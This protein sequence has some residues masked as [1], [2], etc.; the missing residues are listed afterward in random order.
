MCCADG[1]HL[2]RPDWRQHGWSFACY[3]YQ[4]LPPDSY[5]GN[6]PARW[7]SARRQRWRH[8]RWRRP[9]SRRKSVPVWQSR[10]IE[11]RRCAGRVRRRPSRRQ[12]VDRL[13]RHTDQQTDAEAGLS[14]M[15]IDWL[16]DGLSAAYVVRRVGTNLTTLIVNKTKCD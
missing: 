8:C 1:Q 11:D 13:R 6:S 4:V 5:T 14:L 10:D 16:I 9:A 12:S 3:H 7:P 15:M 2:T